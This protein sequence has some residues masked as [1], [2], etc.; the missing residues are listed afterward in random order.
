MTWHDDVSEFHRVM[1]CWD[2]DRS[3]VPDEVRQLRASLIHEEWLEI[4][5]ALAAKDLPALA[6]GLIDLCY[7][8]IGTQVTFGFDGIDPLCL[9]PFN[10]RLPDLYSQADMT[11]ELSDSVAGAILLLGM[12]QYPDDLKRRLFEIVN[13]CENFANRCSMD[14]DPLWQDVHRANMA[15]TTGPVRADGKRLK[16]EGWQPP[17]IAGVLR[18]QGWENAA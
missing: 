10:P 3:N 18:V 1:G 15:K 2:G 4:L 8:T 5:G 9:E 7:V 12:N 6:D 13:C 17:D 14:L 16:P 11:Q